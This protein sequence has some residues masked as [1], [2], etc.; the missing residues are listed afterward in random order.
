[1][2]HVNI[3][4]EAM[5]KQDQ[6][7]PMDRHLQKIYRLLRRGRSPSGQARTFL[8]LCLGLRQL[9]VPHRINDYDY[10]KQHPDEVA[11][12]MGSYNV[13]CKLPWK[14][15]IIYGPGIIEYPVDD[16][17]LMNRL[18]IRT[19]VVYSEWQ[20]QLYLSAWGDRVTVW[21]VG[22]D[23][24]E[25]S[26]DENVEKDID[27]LLYDKMDSY[28]LFYKDA[29]PPERRRNLY[30]REL[31]SPILELA[32]RRGLKTHVIRYGFYLEEKY[33]SLLRRSKAMVFLSKSETQGIAYLQALSSGVPIM[34]WDVAEKWRERLTTERLGDKRVLVTSVPY[35]DQRCGVKFKDF[36][37]FAGQFD[38]FWKALQQQVYAPR[39]YVL[40]NLRLKPQA[41]AYL[42]IW[43]AVQSAS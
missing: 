40:D 37:E 29:G 20:R 26:P 5:P 31:F 14:N 25:W 11:C 13:I 16:P 6:W 35:W 9:G 1:M 21:P 12:I 39:A 4:Y 34:A 30:K 3:F 10:I 7:L 15:P 36:D 28:V 38:E 22:V 27:L 23:T 43:R 32:E 8:N 17:D 2:N 18:P 19:V 33:R 24:D 42:R 41:E